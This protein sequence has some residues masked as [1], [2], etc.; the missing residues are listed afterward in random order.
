MRYFSI[1]ITVML[2]VGVA[3]SG[4]L[5]GDIGAKDSGVLEAL[6]VDGQNNHDWKSTSPVLIRILKDSGLFAVDVAT[7]PAQGQ[8][9]TGF[10]PNFAK[11]DVVVLNYNGDDWP[12]VTQDAFVDYVKNGGG[13]VVIHAADNAFAVWKEYNEIIGIGGWYGRDEK[14]GPL[15]YC[16]DGKFVYDTSAGPGGSHGQFTSYPITVHH[17]D[18][19]IMKGL[20]SRWMHAPDELYC[21]LR[22]PAKNMTLLATGFQ[23]T[24]Q[25]GMGRDEPALFTIAY[26]QGRILHDTLGHDARSMSCV[27]FVVTL[28]RGAEWAATGQVT[29]TKVPEDFPTATQVSTR[30]E[31]TRPE[32]VVDLD[33]IMTWDFTKERK[34]MAAMEEA[35]K[36]ASKRQMR[37]A[38][39][40]LIQVLEAPEATY[41]GKQYVCRVLRQIGSEQCVPALA[42]LLAEQK[43]SHMARRALQHNPCAQAGAALRAALD[44][45]GD[46]NLQI[47]LIGSLGARREA[48][49]ISQI[50]PYLKSNNAALSQAAIRALGHIGGKEAAAILTKA[51]VPESLKALQADSVLM[52][53]D[54]LLAAGQLADAKAYYQNLTTA[55]TASM[56]RVA[57]YRGVIQ[58]NPQDA[59]TVI[60]AMVKDNDRKVQQA[61]GRFIGEAPAGQA[62]T[63]ALA[64]MLPST[65]SEGQIV[66]LA[67]LANRG[68]RAAV[69]HVAPLA[70]S[71]QEGVRVEAV[72]ALGVLGGADQV[73]LL[74]ELST[75]DDESAHAAFVSLTRLTGPDVTAALNRI[76]S[77]H[78]NAAQRK[79]VAEVMQARHE[80]QSLPTLLQATK[81]SD[82]EV[83]LAAI[84]AVGEL[85]TQ[86]ELPAL[87]EMLIASSSS[88]EQSALQAAVL[89]LVGRFPALGSD[90]EKA[91]A[92][93]L[94]GL[95]RANDAGKVNLMPVLPRLGGTK[96]L[97]ALRGQL[98]GGSKVKQAAIRA[99][100]EWP[101]AAPMADLLQLAKSESDMVNHVLALRGFIRLASEPSDDEA[102]AQVASF[103]AAM[104]T[105]RR[106]D[107]KRLVL[108]G[109]STVQDKAALALAAGFQ[110][111]P[112]LEADAAA[113]VARIALPANDKSAGLAGYDVAMALMSALRH[114]KDDN[115]RKAVEA[116]LEKNALPVDEGFTALFNGKDLTGWIGDT[117]GY[118]V[119]DGMIVCK[120]G[121]MLF[122]TSEYSDFVFRFAFKLP[123]NA[124][125]GLGIR[126]PTS[127]DPAYV[128]MELQILDDSGDEYKN[129]QSYQYHGS[130]YGVVAA[131]RGY[132]RPVDQWN[133]QEVIADGDHIKI[134]LNGHTIV[135]ANIRE[136]SAN[137][138]MDHRDHPGLLN[139]KGHIGFLGHGSVVRFRD[140]Q[141][142]TI[143]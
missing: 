3:T 124:N 90:R 109:L 56:I 129:L 27:G 119:E 110:E 103:T 35:L 64:E 98:A 63:E 115:V 127:G 61:A 96:A 5:R 86:K 37:R 106:V 74:A 66:L 73:A 25:H 134:I 121:G 20:P 19:P 140:I 34:P 10:K 62:A 55:G 72:R 9:M 44:Q 2:V 60:A 12:K 57:A 32:V 84:K 117:E 79:R 70:R 95:Q 104:D 92:P 59:V 138:T 132:Q 42:K 101:D 8:D 43:L 11:Y 137:G 49:A 53:A 87:V 112:G 82:S 46:E 38:E 47:G 120:P 133:F 68:D 67:A 58:A 7:S 40:E 15:V 14:S 69:S 114:I 45:V 6:V 142:K 29:W 143:E 116:Y 54:S 125:N 113:A 81:D 135:D 108:A 48:G 89:T 88:S 13:V 51:D 141:I 24:S 99:L 18:H 105:A 139:E 93:I 17:R 75:G 131:E 136:A 1:L 28:V 22:G 76:V 118:A 71:A 4:Q 21:K 31:L 80:A 123:S 65:E 130:V 91:D 39:V 97:A 126:T 33:A 41:A 83:R 94:A 100:A 30:E 85:G 52:C 16:K 77:G 50:A 107:E 128:G 78:P 111:E 26:G 102:A 36:G 23:P 122:T